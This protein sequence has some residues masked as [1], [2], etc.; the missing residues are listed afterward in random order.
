[1]TPT[2]FDEWLSELLGEHPLEVSRLMHDKCAVRFLI[3]WSLFESKCFGGFVKAEQLEDFAD[4]HASEGVDG[5]GCVRKAA[6]HFHE[7]YQDSTRYRHLMHRQR[8]PRM[9]RLLGEPFTALEPKDIV[10]LVLLTVYRYR[11]N[12]FHGN[13]GVAS[14]LQYKEQIE[15]C[16]CVMQR[17][18]TRTEVAVPTMKLHPVA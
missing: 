12:M 15:L 1:M 13:K 16:T 4:R 7:R 10:F 9:D 17:F 5:A 8:S 14:W 2:E 3:A 6:A 18:I 11:N